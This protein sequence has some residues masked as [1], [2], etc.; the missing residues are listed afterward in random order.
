MKRWW[1]TVITVMIVAPV[2][3]VAQQ[4]GATGNSSTASAP[5]PDANKP[6]AVRI[7][8]QVAQGLLIKKVSPHYPKDARQAGIQ[9]M[10]ALKALIDAEGNVTDLTVMM[11]RPELAPAAIEA[12]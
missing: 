1:S 6:S 11:G 8:E 2:F 12:V 7:S 9:G 3:S 4:P 10:V 5:A